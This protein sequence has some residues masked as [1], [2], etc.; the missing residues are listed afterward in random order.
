MPDK[1]WLF[2]G[3]EVALQMA[4]NLRLAFWRCKSSRLGTCD[5]RPCGDLLTVFDPFRLFRFFR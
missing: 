4:P 2:R 1:N 5:L 3:C